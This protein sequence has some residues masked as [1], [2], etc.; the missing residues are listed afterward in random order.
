LVS[1]SDIKLISERDTH[2]R[3]MGVTAVP[4]FIIANKHVVPGSQTPE[5]WATII[6]ELLGQLRS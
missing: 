3:K 6:I 2:S 1:D 4:T 5:V